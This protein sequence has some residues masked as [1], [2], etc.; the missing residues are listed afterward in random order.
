MITDGVLLRLAVDRFW[1][2]QADGDLYSWYK[3]HAQG[4]NV[5][6]HDPEVWVSQIQGP[7]SL[8]VLHAVVDGDYP[9]RFRYFDCA[10]VSIAGQQVVISR[11]GFTNE[12]GWEIYMSPDIDFDALGDHLLEKGQEYGIVLT[13]TPVFRARRIEAGLLNA[14][15]DFD[16][17]TTPFAVG[18]GDFVDFDKPAFVG[19]EALIDAP[20]DCLTWGIRVSEGI[21]A[22]GRTIQ[23]DGETA[24]RVC[25]STW[26]PFLK[27]GVAIARMDSADVG[28]GTSVMV[29][30]IDDKKRSAILCAM[31]FYDEKREIP[32]GKL[33]DIP[34]R[35]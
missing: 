23:L 3:A 9:E 15:S 34:Q 2:A 25:S 17:T 21:A 10:N 14:G 13:A 28:P 16:D 19:R 35:S 32:R 27:C 7:R 33:V 26:S 20:K 24:G 12:L 29:E 8:D 5:R 18:L 11:S 31:P 22:L 1:M 30:C 6:V 4:L